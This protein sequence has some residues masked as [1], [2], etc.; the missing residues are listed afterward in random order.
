[1]QLGLPAGE[2]KLRSAAKARIIRWVKPHKRRQELNAPEWL[3][4]EWASGDKNNIADLLSHMN[5]NKDL[6]HSINVRC[7]CECDTI[8]H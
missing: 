7:V 3:K 4:K 8:T 2:A 1:M 5:F 6:L